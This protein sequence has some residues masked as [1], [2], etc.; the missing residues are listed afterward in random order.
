M[1]AD[2][3][4]EV[5]V[6]H[7]LSGGA[8]VLRVDR[9]LLGSLLRVPLYVPSL[10]AVLPFALAEAGGGDFAALVA[11]STAVGTRMTENFAVGMHF[12]VICAEDLPRVTAAR[13]AEAAATR[14]GTHFVDLYA[15]ACPAVATRPV[16]DAFYDISRVEVPVLLLSGGLDPATPPRHGATVAHRL[17]RARHVVAPNLGHGITG[18]SCAPRLVTR[19]IRD[20]DFG[21]LDFACLEQLPAARFFAPI[22]SEPARGAR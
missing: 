1:R 5:T 15:G 4:F 13:R 22:E 16:P 19:F 14:F 6:P 7:P 2:A 17:G 10:A 9:R 11:L 3:G 12:A 8:Q 18:Q 21:D 20:G